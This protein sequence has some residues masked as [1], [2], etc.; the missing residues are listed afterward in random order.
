MKKEKKAKKKKIAKILQA[1]KHLEIKDIYCYCKL[2]KRLCNF[3]LGNS[4]CPYYT[5]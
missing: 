3:F 2:Q 5:E 4:K 1:C